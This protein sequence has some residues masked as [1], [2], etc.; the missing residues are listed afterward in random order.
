MSLPPAPA[1]GN[2]T[3]LAD[4]PR[5][6]IGVYPDKIIA[7]A[8]DG[9]TEQTALPVYAATG[10]QAA[11]QTG[12]N[13]IACANPSGL[14]AVVSTAVTGSNPPFVGGTTIQVID[15]TGNTPPL[16]SDP[17]YGVL[18]TA[19]A[20]SLD[21]TEVLFTSAFMNPGPKLVAVDAT[22]MKVTAQGGG[23]FELSG[24]AVTADGIFTTFLSYSY[25]TSS[26]SW[27]IAKWDLVGGNGYE[28]TY[29]YVDGTAGD[30]CPLTAG[31]MG[32]LFACAMAFD[33]D[34][35]RIN[36]TG[37]GLGAMAW[38]SS[39]D[40]WYGYEA[41]QAYL[42]GVNIATDTEAVVLA[43]PPGRS[44]MNVAAE[45]QTVVNAD[46]TVAPVDLVVAQS[47]DAAL[48]FYRV[49]PPALLHSIV[50]SA[51]LQAGSFA[52]GQFITLFGQGVG[53]WN[54]NDVAGPA[55]RQ[56]GNTQ[57]LLDAK[58]L[59]LYYVG[60][61]Q[62][63]AALPQ[64]LTSGSHIVGAQVAGKS[65]GFQSVTVV[66]QAVA[67]FMWTPDPTQPSVL[68]PIITNALYELVGPPATALGTIG[69]AQ[70]TPTYSQASPG[71]TVVLWGTGC[72]RTTPTLDDDGVNGATLHPCN[73]V[74]QI[75]VD[76]MPASVSFAGRTPASGYASLDQFN[77]AVP[78]GLA[79]GAHDLT[80]ISAGG[81]SIT[82]KGGLWTK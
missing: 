59:R 28:P 22:T 46:G 52:P 9:T 5:G 45:R 32:Y 81:Q 3:L 37:Y 57:A 15:P 48:D 23:G 29:P 76:G 20:W 34:G 72:G 40:P 60:Y 47:A 63:N 71:E 43:V 61:G 10:Q 41:Y 70:P 53:G 16:V 58:P 39:T 12:Y 74:P 18:A 75:Q 4:W 31:P 36:G 8:T 6:V 24:I 33:Q 64:N 73:L 35:K 51:S 21:G 54:E 30:W 26:D 14:V 78:L 80:I 1:G 68:A 65:A 2:P 82:Y 11:G 77:F 67:A 56:L 17:I 27:G 66:D 19:C 79:P 49:T 44:Y 38:P 62:V 69:G 55:V 25:T 50:S 7:V 42:A 13:V